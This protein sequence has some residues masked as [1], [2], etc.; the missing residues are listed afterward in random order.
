M[1]E[2]KKSNFF[3]LTANNFPCSEYKADEVSGY[4]DSLNGYKYAKLVTTHSELKGL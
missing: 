1:T 4:P 2:K 3:P